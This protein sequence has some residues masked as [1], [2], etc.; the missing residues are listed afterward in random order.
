[1]PMI[2][3]ALPIPPERYDAWRSAVT[4]FAG[5]RRDEYTAARVRQGVTR[6]G[7]FVHHT[8]EGPVEIM[9]MEADDLDRALAEIATSQEPF[10]VEFRRFLMDVY[11]LDLA[12]P[13]SG[14][15]PELLLDW[16]APARV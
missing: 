7:V 9:V 2:V 3:M 8:A 16:S 10:D 13:P 6:Q 4:G 5:P 14:P 12:Q 15:L 11:G 1:M